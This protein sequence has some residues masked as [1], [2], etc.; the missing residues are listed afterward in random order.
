MYVA[1]NRRLLLPLITLA[2]LCAASTFTASR[3][4]AACTPAANDIISPSCFEGGD[5]NLV[6]DNAN[7]TGRIDWAS[8]TPSTFTDGTGATDS[9]FAGGSAGKQNDPG[10]WALIEGPNPAK[11]DV[12][13]VA[14]KTDPVSN[15]IFFYGA[16]HRFGDT[17]NANVSFE[18]NKVATLFDND[19]SAATP[20]VPFR[21]EGDA[22]ITFDGGAGNVRVGM[23]LWHGDEDGES[24]NAAYGWYTLPGFGMPGAVKIDSNTDCTTLSTVD[25]ATRVAFGNV[26]ASA[27]D[28]T[29]NGGPTVLSNFPD[30]IVANTF[31]EVSVDLTAAL[32][33][34]GQQNPCFDFG[35]VW[36]HSRSSDTIVANMQDYVTPH[37][38]VGARSCAISVDKQVAV[39]SAAGPY[40]QG[41]PADPSWANTGDTLYYTLAVRND[42][43]VPVVVDS[44]ADPNCSAATI[45]DADKRNSANALDATPTSFDPGDVWTYRCSHVLAGGDPEPYVNTVTVN[46]HVGSAPGP[47]KNLTATDSVSTGRYGRVV[48]RKDNVGGNAT[49]DFTFTP[50]GALSAGGNF[51]WGES[52]GDK[53]FANLLPNDSSATEYSLTEPAA[54]Q[55]AD[56]SLTGITCRRGPGADDTVD[57]DTT[58]SLANRKA[59]VKVSAGESV[60]CTF[61]NTKA[62]KLTVIKQVVNDNGGAAAAGAWTMNVTATNPSS[63]SFAGSAGTTITVDPGA[64][65]VGE[66]GGP[67]GY[68]LQSSVGC[69]GNIAVGQ[70]LTCTLV[71]NDVAPQLTV[72][73]HV[74]NDSGGDKSAG[75]FTMEVDGINVSDDEF[76]GSESGTTVTLDAGSYD[77]DE[78]ELDGY[79][80]SESAN[81]TGTIAVGQTRTCTITNDDIAAS[82]TVIKHVVNKGGSDASAG[83]FT[84]NVTG[85]DVSDDSFAGTEAPGTT[86]SLDAGSYSVDESGGPAHYTKSLSAGCAGTIALGESKSCTITNTRNTGTIEVVKNLVPATDT[87]TFDLLVDDQVEKVGASNGEGTGQVEV[88]TGDHTVSEAG[89]LSHYVSAITCKL[90]ETTVAQG[91]GSGPLTVAV[92]KDEHVVCTITNTR[93]PHVVIRKVLDPAEPGNETQFG[94]A[95]DLPAGGGVGADG[96]FALAHGEDVDAEVAPGAYAVSENDPAGAGY[97]L[98]ALDCDDPSSDSTA[99]LGSRSVSIQADPGETVTCT[100]RNRRVTAQTVVI[101][102]G[103]EFA[104][105]GDTV[106]YQFAVT[107]SGNSPLSDVHVTDDRCKDV[108][109]APVNKLN[110]DGDAFLDPVG[111]DGE[112]S[113]QWIYSCSMKVGDHADGEEDPIVN[114]ATVTAKDELGRVVTDV[115][116]HSTN[117]LHP[118]VAIDKTGPA[119]ALAGSRIEYTLAVGNTGD[120][121]FAEA[122][123][124]LTDELCEAPPALVSKN[125]DGSPATLD[126]G[127]S[128]TYSCTV[129][130]AA[131]QNLVHNVASVTATDQNGRMATASDSADTALARQE[132]LPARVDPGSAR[133]RGPSGCPTARSVRAT[134]SG[135]QIQS[136]TFFLDGHR[137]RTVTKPDT[138]GRWLVTMY[139]RRLSYGQHRV[140]A[141][142]QFTAASA[143][144][145]RNLRLTFARCRPPV[146]RPKFTG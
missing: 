26:N 124:V 7:G 58:V 57:S 96:S 100:F 118:A 36:M 43:A 112:H 28:N 48:L 49:D 111:A 39:G 106:T 10:A 52:D 125:G 110:D 90:G 35:G 72:V 121:P 123:V 4:H 79:A 134:V 44:L 116:Q 13:A 34:P 38:L 114:T 23:C 41:T 31:G 9:Q 120:M 82:L 65:S 71:N 132:V 95:S 133:L 117:L 62:T 91:S 102:T 136:V 11:T 33:T 126:P 101:K 24:S 109:A 40:H 141:R 105:H 45:A 97:K 131:D 20:P 67:S 87:G 32:S 139:P 144:P 17:G 74:V 46:A 73:K 86:V 113:E 146:I 94:F 88:A 54:G 103:S 142:I 143:T 84:M 16:F 81:C 59:T 115:D 51:L 92:G 89:A 22:M 138:H 29:P 61:T 50:S 104:Y 18:L 14:T 64:Y 27:L 135:R 15:H 53:V 108:S 3:A 66:S 1:C 21:S 137:I 42:G 122:L 60:Y 98:L 107:A 130:S 2:L 77:V 85:S 119:V 78:V 128:W 63:A 37:A 93:K 47:V 99:S 140:R 55:P 19:G 25:L 56:Y 129:Q 80:K 75:D 70:H 83:D 69:A 145:V 6:V 68:A 5:G 8:L 12:L 30:S 76:P 127:E